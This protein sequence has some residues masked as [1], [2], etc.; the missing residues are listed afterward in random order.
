META[1][2]GTLVLAYEP[3][4][5]LETLEQSSYS[6]LSDGLTDYLKDKE[7][8]DLFMFVLTEEGAGGTFTFAT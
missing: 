6:E 7:E 8:G 4:A 5:F 2:E 1:D 3:K